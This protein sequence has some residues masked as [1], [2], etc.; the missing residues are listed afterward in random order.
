MTNIPNKYKVMLVDI[1]YCLEHCL[2]KP[3]KQI[4]PTASP[5]DV[6]ALFAQGLILPEVVVIVA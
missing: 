6:V 2:N 1:T 5:L 3:S 4:D